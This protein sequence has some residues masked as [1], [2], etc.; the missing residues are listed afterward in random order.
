MT[1][2]Q[3]I[4]ARVASFR[5]ATH[6]TKAPWL[7]KPSGVGIWAAADTSAPWLSA[8]VRPA[9]PRRCRRPRTGPPC[10]APRLVRRLGSRRRPR[11]RGPRSRPRRRPR[12]ASSA[13][14][15]RVGGGLARGAAANTTP[16]DIASTTKAMPRPRKR[17]IRSVNG[18][19]LWAGGACHERVTTGIAGAV[20]GTSGPGTAGPRGA[21]AT[22]HA[23]DPGPDDRLRAAARHAGGV[24]AEAALSA[25]SHA[26]ASRP[27]PTAWISQASSRQPGP[28]PR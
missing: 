13:L 2:V 1:V 8:D 17:R 4:V 21:H 10:R 9:R 5:W 20:R 19:N 12:W 6:E 27:A 15:T 14:G 22:H 3:S 16:A 7:R 28:P 18:W 11:S 23:V 24:A 26:T 25:P